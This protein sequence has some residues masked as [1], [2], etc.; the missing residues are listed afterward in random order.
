MPSLQFA[1]MQSARKRAAK[2]AKGEKVD[3]EQFLRMEPD[4][5]TMNIATPREQTLE[6][7]ARSG[8]SLRGLL[9]LIQ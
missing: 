8:T 5:G 6:T 3:F 9:P 1:L 2:L 7:M 4:S